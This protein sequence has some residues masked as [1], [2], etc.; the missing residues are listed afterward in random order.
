MGVGLRELGLGFRVEGTHEF[1][2]KDARSAIPRVKS[3]RR[4]MVFLL[5]L[6]DFGLGLLGCTGDLISCVNR[7]V[8]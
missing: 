8:L 5:C 3:W 7:Q 1:L 6:E 2:L 4:S